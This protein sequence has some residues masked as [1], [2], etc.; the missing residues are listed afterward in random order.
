MPRLAPVIECLAF[1]PVHA[2]TVRPVQTMMK[3]PKARAMTISE[4]EISTAAALLRAG[5]LVAFPT[6]TVYGLGADAMNDAA[7]AAVFAAKGR[8]KFNPL[9]SHVADAGKAMELGRL[10]SDAARLAEAF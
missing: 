9:I 6:E 10:N 1:E 7:V 2:T 3:C 4:D 5:K 8:P